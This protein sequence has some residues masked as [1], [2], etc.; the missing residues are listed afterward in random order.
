MSR[1]DIFVLKIAKLYQIWFLAIFLKQ[2]GV[3]V[4]FKQD[5]LDIT[6]LYTP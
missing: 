4:K 2:T 1:E 3:S 6:V 5:K